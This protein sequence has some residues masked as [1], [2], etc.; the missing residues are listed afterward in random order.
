[1]LRLLKQF[2]LDPHILTYYIVFC[3]N[4]IRYKLNDITSL[5]S[6]K[7]WFNF[8]FKK[9]DC[10]T[11]RLF[12]ITSLWKIVYI[13]LKKKANFVFIFN[14][15]EIKRLTGVPRHDELNNNIKIYS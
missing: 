12:I 6:V 5:W 9:N 13:G 2:F 8:D 15:K 3:E 4:C 1:M 11:D 10:T 14:K 7:F